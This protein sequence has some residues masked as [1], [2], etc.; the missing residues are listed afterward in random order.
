MLLKLFHL[1]F[2]VLLAS[3]G[4]AQQAVEPSYNSTL[5]VGRVASRRKRFI[6]FPKGSSLQVSNIHLDKRHSASRRFDI[7][8]F[9]R[10]ARELFQTIFAFSI[11][12][13]ERLWLNLMKEK[14]L[15]EKTTRKQIELWEMRK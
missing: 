1:S 12:V 9:A 13:S 15:K 8:L 11:R 14:N 7:F 6:G 10:T 5:D 4:S 3:L 2:L